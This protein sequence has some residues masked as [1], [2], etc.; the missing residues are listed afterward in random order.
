MEKRVNI[1]SVHLTREQ[2]DAVKSLCQKY[3]KNFSENWKDLGIT[4][5]I[6]HQIK[7]KPNAQ[8]FRRAYENMRFDK[9]K[10]MKKIVEGLANADLITPPHSDWAAP[11]IL[12]PK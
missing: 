1:N 11:S 4:N 8:T 5:Q 10:I 7:L 9:R 3:E 12:V 6:E 2:L